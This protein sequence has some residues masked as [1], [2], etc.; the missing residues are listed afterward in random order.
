[1]NRSKELIMD[2]ADTGDFSDLATR[3]MGRANVTLAF[4]GT[5][6]CGL[7]AVID[8][9]TEE[10]VGIGC[11]ECAWGWRLS[12]KLGGI[13]QKRTEGEDESR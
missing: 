3:M 10:F 4:C 7:V 6:E 8:T 13:V 1:M 12:I 5:C 9:E 11:P 2:I